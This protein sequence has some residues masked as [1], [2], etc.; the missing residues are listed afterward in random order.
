MQ[1]FQQ[2]KNYLIDFLLLTLIEQNNKPFFVNEINFF[3]I[4]LITNSLHV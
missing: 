2:I 3:M 4:Y 1:N